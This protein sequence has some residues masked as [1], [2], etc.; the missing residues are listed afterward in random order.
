MNRRAAVVAVYLPHPCRAI[1]PGTVAQRCL[2]GLAPP[3]EVMAELVQLDDGP[4]TMGARGLGGLGAALSAPAWPRN[5]QTPN[6]N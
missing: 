2:E 4:I 1:F 5:P 3:A 6:P